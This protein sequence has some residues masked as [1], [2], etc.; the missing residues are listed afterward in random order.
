MFKGD[1]VKT[2]NDHSV[3]FSAETVVLAQKLYAS[4][5]ALEGILPACSLSWLP[6][7]QAMLLAS[8]SGKGFGAVSL[9]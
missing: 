7:P 1:N 3:L 9:T 8:E 6:L 5:E 4:R 2:K